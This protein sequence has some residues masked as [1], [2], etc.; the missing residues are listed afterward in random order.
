[1]SFQAKS[2]NSLQEAS[3]KERRESQ[4]FLS[5]SYFPDPFV[6]AKDFWIVYISYLHLM[7]ENR[8]QVV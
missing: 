5:I 3:L 7:H 8:G 1:M 2:E 4:V 6:G